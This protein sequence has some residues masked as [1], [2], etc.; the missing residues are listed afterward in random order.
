L[1]GWFWEKVV[2]A[3]TEC[4][5][6]DDD[7]TFKQNFELLAKLITAQKISHPRL[8]LTAV[9]AQFEKTTTMKAE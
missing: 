7:L 3:Y 4:R 9:T 2:A 5:F 8:S 1:S 6:D